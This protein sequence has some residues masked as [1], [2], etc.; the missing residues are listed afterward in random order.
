MTPTD[1]KALDLLQARKIGMKAY[2]VYGALRQYAQPGEIFQMSG[3]QL[4]R[5]THLPK[6]TVCRA[7]DELAQEFEELGG[8]ALLRMETPKLRNHGMDAR[9]M[10][11][12]KFS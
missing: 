3:S 6:N 11:I 8:K 5:Y 4:C 10:K 1:Q 2:Q 7:L 12:T 9:K